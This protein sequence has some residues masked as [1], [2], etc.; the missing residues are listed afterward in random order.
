M[1][2]RKKVEPM[3][4]SIP[5]IRTEVMEITVI[6]DSPL[7][8]HKWS[9]KAKKMMLDKQRGVPTQKKPPKD[10]QQDFQDAIHYDDDGDYA[11]PTIGFKASAVTACTSLDM[12]KVAARQAF[13][14]E[15]EWVKIISDPP[16]MDESMV[17][18]GQGTADL[19]YRP[20]YQN[21]AAKFKVVY[22]ANVLTAGQILNVFNTAGFGVGIGEWRPEKNGSYG[23]FHVANKAEADALE[24]RIAAKALE[25]AA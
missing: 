20:K 16:E 22:N 6:G 4:I 12:Q 11:F 2:A 8:V 25:I 5:D 10:P 14:M 13:H 21:W 23:R 7:M 9:E 18:I 19:R 15:G 3:S 1:A 24:K 17:R